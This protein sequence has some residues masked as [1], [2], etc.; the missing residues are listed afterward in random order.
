MFL[1][2]ENKKTLKNFLDAT[3]AVAGNTGTAFKEELS[4]VGTFYDTKFLPGS[5]LAEPRISIE[6]F[7]KSD[8]KVK[9]TLKPEANQVDQ[10]VLLDG[11]LNMI[12]KGYLDE[13]LEQVKEQPKNF[14]PSQAFYAQ[15]SGM[16]EI[17]NYD[18]NVY[19]NDPEVTRQDTTIDGV[20]YY[21]F[22]ITDEFVGAGLTHTHTLN[23]LFKE[24]TS[25]GENFF[26]ALVDKELSV[27]D[28][29][30]VLDTLADNNM[31]GLFIGGYNYGD[32]GKV[33]SQVFAIS[34][35]LTMHYH[36]GYSIR[37]YSSDLYIPEETIQSVKVNRSGEYR[38]NVD[39]RTTNGEITLFIG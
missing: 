4:Y 36:G 37:G 22:S 23:C 29:K 7:D 24:K 17:Q 34:S 38:Y 32:P 35:E 39:I 26:S 21:L 16:S 10:V 30:K 3:Q 13:Q 5:V 27:K 2:K 8:I 28:S 20:K 18:L 11:F 31:T 19:F 1:F 33:V 12:G 6:S 25:S 15:Q 14:L 9:V